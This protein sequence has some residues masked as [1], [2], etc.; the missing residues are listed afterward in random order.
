MAESA[1]RTH[2]FLLLLLIAVGGAA[3][4]AVKTISNPAP[5]GNVEAPTGSAA[6]LLDAASAGDVG[7]IKAAIAAGAVVDSRYESDDAARRG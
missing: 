3:V 6:S 2:W 1:R 7:A 4:Y 5:T